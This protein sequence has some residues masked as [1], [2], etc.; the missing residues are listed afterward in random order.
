MPQI[1][2][3][4]T[5]ARNACIAGDL[6]TAEKILTQEINAN[7]NEYASYANR[8]F[9]MARKHQ[10]DHALQDA[11]KVRYTDPSRAIMRG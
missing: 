6:S 7:A 1:L 10:W 11:I 3:I 5:P 2:A 9:V 4:D 8:S